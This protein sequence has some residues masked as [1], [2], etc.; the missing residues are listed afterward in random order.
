MLFGHLGAKK[1][2]KRM[3]E[4]HKCRWCEKDLGNLIRY[5]FCM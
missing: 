4:M 5:N 2:K 1:K 3:K